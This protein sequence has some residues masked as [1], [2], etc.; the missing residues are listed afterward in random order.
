MMYEGL[1]R[2]FIAFKLLYRASNQAVS[3]ASVSVIYYVS[4]SYSGMQSGG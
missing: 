2:V 3:V 4:P 1:I